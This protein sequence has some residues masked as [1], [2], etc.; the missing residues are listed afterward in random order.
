M[1]LSHEEIDSRLN[2]EL[3]ALL[4]EG[5][6][7]PPIDYEMIQNKVTSHMKLFGKP[8]HCG[9]VYNSFKLNERGELLLGEKIID[10][11]EDIDWI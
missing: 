8:I 1:E 3:S 11:G 2:R 9:T 5:I 6:D 7:L 4:E 10:D